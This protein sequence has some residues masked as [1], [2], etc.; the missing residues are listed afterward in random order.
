MAIDTGGPAYPIGDQS[1]HPLCT[2]MTLLDWFAGQAMVAFVQTRQQG[3]MENGDPRFP[4]HPTWVSGD[5][6][7]DLSKNS[8]RMATAMIDEKRRLGKESEAK[9]EA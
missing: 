8:Y 3:R 7:D 1:M 4:Q 5:T 2:G 6:Y 9:S